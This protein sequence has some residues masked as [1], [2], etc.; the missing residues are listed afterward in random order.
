MLLHCFWDCGDGHIQLQCST[1]F[2]KKK[3]RAESRCRILDLLVGA[4]RTT[5]KVPLIWHCYNGIDR[6]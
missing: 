4:A 3:P 2:I 1:S 6:H 5:L